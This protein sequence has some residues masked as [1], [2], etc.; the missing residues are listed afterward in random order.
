MAQPTPYNRRFNFQN[1]QMVNPTAPL[2]ADQV[3]AE[4][5]AAKLTLDQTLANLAKIQRDD[6]VLKNGVVTKDS[7]APSLSIGFTF[8]GSWAAGINYLAGDGVS[9]G[10]LFYKA[11][12]S[13]LSALDSQPNPLGDN[14][15]W[16]LIANITPLSIGANSVG[17]VALQDL[18]VT[19]EKH[20]DGS[21]VAQKLAD[22]AAITS[23][24]GDKAVTA[25]KQGDASV[26]AR[27]LAGS[28]LGPRSGMI[29]GTLV[30]SRTASAET[31]AV[32]TLAGTDPSAADPVLFVFQA[33]TGSYTVRSV[34]TALSVTASSGSTLGTTNSTPFRIWCVAADDAGTVRLG[35]VK[36]TAV[37]ATAT[38]VMAL[39]EWAAYSSTAEAGAGSADSAQVIYSDTA[40]TAK[41]LCLIGF[42]DWDSG[43]TTAGTWS[44]APTRTITYGPGVAR[45]GEP[46]GNRR[47]VLKTDTFSAAS[48]G[49]FVDVTGL[50]AS[51]TPVSAANLVRCVPR[52]SM[53]SMSSGYGGGAALVRGSTNIGGGTAVSNR[54]SV[55]A[56]L[57]RTTDQNS[58]NTLTAE[59]LDAPG[60]ATSTAYKV[61]V[62]AESGATIRVNNAPADSDLLGLGRPSSSLMLEEIMA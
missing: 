58:F 61:Q 38:N 53:A 29:N 44:S 59:I 60:A 41:Y 56:G 35:I 6:G 55:F 51:I 52:V 7:L 3:D 48:S 5:N 57:V 36:T 9:V 12:L 50:S 10:S 11:K 19:A 17:T 22:G 21:V 2:P 26:I 31:F 62:V 33:G 24:I 28:V 30:Q 25:A 32:K 8:R 18:S 23:K 20:A 47:H 34:T 54:P 13:H 40:F 43:L 42:G 4:F 39:A 27:A 15:T 45:P 46:T 49:A 16:E 14:A 37:S 1:F